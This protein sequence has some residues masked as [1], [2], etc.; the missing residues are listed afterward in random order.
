MTRTRQL[1]SCHLGDAANRWPSRVLAVND[2]NLL[3][4]A[5]LALASGR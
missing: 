2:Y 3:P 4:A 1:P 5:T